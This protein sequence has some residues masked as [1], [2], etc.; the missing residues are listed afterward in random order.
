MNH[1]LRIKPRGKD[2]PSPLETLDGNKNNEHPPHLPADTTAFQLHWNGAF[3]TRNLHQATR[4]K[5]DG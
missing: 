2:V 3:W 4:R 5:L 1:W